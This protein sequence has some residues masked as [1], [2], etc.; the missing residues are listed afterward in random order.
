MTRLSIAN[1]HMTIHITNINNPKRY[2]FPEMHDAVSL[3][4][5]AVSIIDDCLDDD[6]KYGREPIDIE[7]MTIYIGDNKDFYGYAG[8]KYVY[9]NGTEYIYPS[10]VFINR[11]LLEKSVDENISLSILIHEL[12][13]CTIFKSSDYENDENGNR[14]GRHHGI[15]RERVNMIMNKYPNIT[16]LMDYNY[17][18]LIEDFGVERNSYKL[19]YTA[20]MNDTDVDEYIDIA[21]RFDNDEEHA[22]KIL[23]IQ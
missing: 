18:E 7:N 21:S 22:R 6:L 12:L 17:D 8:F 14:I 9:I 5:K 16:P 1:I 2:F 19:V 3:I 4:K 15:W 23:N 10:Y 20:Y 13:H 11:Y